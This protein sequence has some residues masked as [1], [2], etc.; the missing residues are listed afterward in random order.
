MTKKMFEWYTRTC[1]GVLFP[2]AFAILDQRL[3]S[4]GSWGNT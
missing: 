1:L 4:T 2:S 3:A